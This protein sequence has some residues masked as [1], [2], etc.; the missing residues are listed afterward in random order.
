MTVAGVGEAVKL[1]G[2]AVEPTMTK[3][4][5]ISFRG[6]DTGGLAAGDGDADEEDA[7]EG[8]CMSM[9]SC[10]LKPLALR[11]FRM[12]I[13]MLLEVSFASFASFT[14]QTRVRNHYR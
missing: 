2:A 1:D 5:E 6:G 14:E 12:R 13:P 7:A 8:D 9:E 10:D 11:L 3:G 4:G